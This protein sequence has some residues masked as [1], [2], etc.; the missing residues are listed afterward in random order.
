MAKKEQFIV[1]LY[2][3]ESDD[4]E[5]QALE[6]DGKDKRDIASLLETTIDGWSTFLIHEGQPHEGASAN[7]KMVWEVGCDIDVAP[8]DP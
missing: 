2:L 6:L 5:L 3:D 8:L 7:A 4:E 1:T